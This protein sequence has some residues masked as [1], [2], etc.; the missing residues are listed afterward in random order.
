MVTAI[1]ERD[2]DESEGMKPQHQFSEES[3]CRSSSLETVV[4]VEPA[5]SVA[6]ATELLGRGE[7]F[8]AS[9]FHT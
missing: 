4:D 8:S 2:G 9:T 1:N 6:P 5:P 3:L 7:T